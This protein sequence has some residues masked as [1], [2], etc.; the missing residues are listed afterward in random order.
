[1][2]P[3][4]TTTKAKRAKPDLT[5][6]LA[7]VDKATR[8]RLVVEFKAA[9]RARVVAERELVKATN[10][11]RKVLQKY[12]DAGLSST[13]IGAIVGLTGARVL[14]IMSHNGRGE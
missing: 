2:T 11:R 14:Q 8:A 5:R 1:M 7:A 13:T 9:E 10:A 4:K 6:T 3:A 12:Y